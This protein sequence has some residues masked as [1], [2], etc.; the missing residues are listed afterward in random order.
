MDTLFEKIQQASLHELQEIMD[1]IAE[2]YAVLYPDWDVIYVAVHKD[3]ALRKA[4]LAQ[5]ISQMEK[6]LGTA[7]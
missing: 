5:I 4:E 7:L 6:D 3:P 1:E 2:R